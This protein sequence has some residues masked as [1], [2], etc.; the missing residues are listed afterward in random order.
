MQLLVI[1]LILIEDK[2][3]L[4]V[5]N[6]FGQQWQLWFGAQGDNLELILFVTGSRV[7]VFHVVGDD[8]F[9]KEVLLRRQ[10]DLGL[11]LVSFATITHFYYKFAQDSK[12]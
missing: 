8:I 6:L 12:Y 11:K 5:E 3:R 2:L 10:C 7:L 1:N 9:V 4:L